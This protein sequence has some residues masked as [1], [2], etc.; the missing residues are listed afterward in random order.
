MPR[1]KKH[2]PGPLYCR[3]EKRRTGLKAKTSKAWCPECN[4]KIR[5]KNHE[6]GKHHTT[7]IA[8]K[9]QYEI[10]KVKIYG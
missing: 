6:A 2:R 4:F 5:G 10:K 1:D 8:Q 9:G 7:V 3:P